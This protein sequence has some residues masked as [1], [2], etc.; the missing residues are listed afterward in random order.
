MI[1]GT[2][3]V[4]ANGGLQASCGA[5]TVALSARHYSV[6]LY[7]CASIA[8]LTPVHASPQGGTGGGQDPLNR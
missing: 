5:Y 4:L 8:K 3:A 1:I 2:S 6:P 7:V